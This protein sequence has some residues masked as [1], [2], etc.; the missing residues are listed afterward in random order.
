MS[1]QHSTIIEEH[2]NM[3]VLSNNI[4]EFQEKNLKSW[5]FIVF[6]DLK[7][8]AVNF[9]FMDDDGLFFAGNIDYNFTFGEMPEDEEKTTGL[10]AL[11]E[12]VSMLFWT[13]TK[14]TFKVNGVEW[15]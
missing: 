11:S 12:W 6:K 1:K 14:V 13:D 4:S 9:N 3:L 15:K 2:R 10:R 7:Q 5:P 8:V